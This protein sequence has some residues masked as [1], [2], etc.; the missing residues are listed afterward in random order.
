LPAVIVQ[1]RYDVV[2]PPLSAL[3]LHT[4]WPEAKLHLVGDA[5]HSGYEPGIAAALVAAT[6]QFKRQRHFD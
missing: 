1:G 2:C 6:E 3:R 4:A 5:G